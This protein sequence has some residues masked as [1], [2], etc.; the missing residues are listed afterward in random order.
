MLK[1]KK[2]HN[3]KL[4]MKMPGLMRKKRMKSTMDLKILFLE[5]DQS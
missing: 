5:M 4:K 3:L 2:I 1:L